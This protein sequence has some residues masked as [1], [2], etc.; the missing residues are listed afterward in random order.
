MR[1]EYRKLG[2]EFVS[3]EE[4][5]SC[6]PKKTSMVADKKNNGAKDYINLFLEQALMRQRDKMMENF[7]HILQHL[8]IAIDT[9]SSSGHFG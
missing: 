6:T 2:L 3:L 8:L 4:N 9:S 7:S 1:S 5:R